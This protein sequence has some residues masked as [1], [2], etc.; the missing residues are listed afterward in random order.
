M[1]LTVPFMLSLE[2]LKYTL[3]EIGEENQQFW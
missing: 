2:V 1:L 3:I